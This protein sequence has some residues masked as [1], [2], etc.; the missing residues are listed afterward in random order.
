M[1]GADLVQSVVKALDMLEKISESKSGLRLSDIAEE[2][3]MNV[4]TAHN[5]LRTL[6]SRGYLGKDGVNRYHLGEAVIGLIRNE[7]NNTLFNAA[8]RELKNMA[9]L[10]PDSVLTVAELVGHEPQTRLRIS[11]DRPSMIQK[12]LNMVHPVYWSSTGLCFMAQSRF[13]PRLKSFW[14]FEEYGASRWGSIDKLN[15]FLEESRKHGYVKLALAPSEDWTLAES[16]G[17]NFALCIKV[18]SANLGNAVEI[19][20]ESAQNIRKAGWEI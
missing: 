1:A 2:L 4:K 13:E 3:D 17:E 20:R 15:Q 16:L 10:L 14:T 9:R 19:L 7:Q 18:N 12:P 11:P 6:L 8:S 5:L